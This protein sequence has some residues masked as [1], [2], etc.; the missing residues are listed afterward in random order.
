MCG[1]AALYAEATTFRGRLGPGREFHAM[2]WEHGLCLAAPDKVGTL[3]P[4][5]QLAR[6]TPDHKPRLYSPVRQRNP[7]AA[8][9]GIACRIDDDCHRPRLLRRI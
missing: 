6:T 9:L 2:S 1:P 5:I 3:V 7:G 8:E 4:R